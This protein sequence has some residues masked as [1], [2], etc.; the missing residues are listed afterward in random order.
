MNKWQL[1]NILKGN[2]RKEITM[3]TVKDIE[4]MED[5]EVKEAVLE[6]MTEIARNNINYSKLAI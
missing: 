3:E 6:L 2:H 1:N 4:I 5:E